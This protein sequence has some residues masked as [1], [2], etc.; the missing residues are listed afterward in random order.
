M[1]NFP[2]ISNKFGREMIPLGTAEKDEG[3]R[4]GIRPEKVRTSGEGLK[5]SRAILLNRGNETGIE[6]RYEEP[7][8]TTS[9]LS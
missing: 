1:C 9:S 3:S 8:D 6:K 7:Y 4:G 5:E 2:H